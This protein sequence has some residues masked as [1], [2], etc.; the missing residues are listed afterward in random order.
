[1]SFSL[2]FYGSLKNHNEEQL[3]E[4]LPTVSWNKYIGDSGFW[5]ESFQN[6]QSEFLSVASIVIL[7]IWLRQKGSPESKPVDAPHSETGEADNAY[8]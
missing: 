2:H 6:W 5:F 7:S 8:S 1:M 4:G 3:E